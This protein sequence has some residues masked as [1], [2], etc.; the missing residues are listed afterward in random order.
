MEGHHNHHAE[1]DQN[2]AV[3]TT[4]RGMFDFMKKKD[5]DVTMADAYKPPA[6]EE[7]KPTLLEKLH[8][9]DSSSVSLISPYNGDLGDHKEE[10]TEHKDTTNIPTENPEEKKGFLDK[11]KEKLPGQHKKPEEGTA[12]DVHPPAEGEPKEKGILEKIKEKIPG[13]HGHKTEDHLDK[14]KDN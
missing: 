10:A 13:C 12:H 11:I 3:E 7:E 8:R 2:K 14:P 6:A 4:D 5:D 1:G 9:S